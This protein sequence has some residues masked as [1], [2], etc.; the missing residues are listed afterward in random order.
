MPGAKSGIAK[1]PGFPDGPSPR[2][3][4][5]ADATG[6]VICQFDHQTFGIILHD[7]RVIFVDDDATPGMAESVRAAEEVESLVERAM[8]VG[9]ATEAGLRRLQ[10]F[11][12]N[13]L[14][15]DT[16]L[17]LLGAPSIMEGVAAQFDAIGNQ[18]GASSRRRATAT[19]LVGLGL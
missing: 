14:N 8:P 16:M 18:L 19:A 11:A 4:N 12:V 2:I 9:G 5:I 1:D 10:M 6:N 17:R 3:W 15:A 13:R 7:A